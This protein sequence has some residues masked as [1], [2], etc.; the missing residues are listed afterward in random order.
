MS[1]SKE[2]TVTPPPEMG[3]PKGALADLRQYAMSLPVDV[4][5]AGLVEYAERRHALR[6]WIRS[7]MVE[8]VHFGVPPGCEPRNRDSLQWVNKPSLYAAG[9]DF[10]CDMMGFIDEYQADMDS[11]EQLGKPA[12][13]FIRK[14]VL[15]SKATGMKV[16]EGSGARKEGTKK[17][18]I[19]ATIK[20]ADKCAKVNAVLNAF[21]LR[22]LFTQDVEHGEPEK[23]DNPARNDRAPKASPRQDRRAAGGDSVTKEELIAAYRDFET[24]D[25]SDD[26]KKA[27]PEFV[28]TATGLNFDVR[29]P[30]EWT[31]QAMNLTRKKIAENL[32]EPPDA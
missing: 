14:C 6:D 8:G 5:Q 31:R 27:F 23:Q 1:E 11:W 13:T 22:D 16:S 26:S 7:Q 18:D 28:Y 32:G 25:Q 19:N 24:F 15:T 30:A 12:G 4:M 21:G 3:P 17:M 10:I 29:Q 9:A 20:M 2:L